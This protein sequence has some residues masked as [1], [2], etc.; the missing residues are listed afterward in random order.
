MKDI[1]IHR[2]PSWRASSIGTGYIDYHREAS[3]YDYQTKTHTIIPG[4]AFNNKEGIYTL[5]FVKSNT[6]YD[7]V[8]VEILDGP[9]QALVGVE[10]LLDYKV[11][12]EVLNAG[13]I[14][15][16][17]TYLEIRETLKFKKIGILKLTRP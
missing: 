16:T 2:A 4:V 7:A 6:G 11:F 10:A 14:T 9:N 3:Y 13:R 5:R 12:D 1:Y 15:Y 8:R 17:G